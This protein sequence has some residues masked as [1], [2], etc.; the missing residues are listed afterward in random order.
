VRDHSKKPGRDGKSHHVVAKP[1]TARTTHDRS[2]DHQ[3]LAV[4][5]LDTPPVA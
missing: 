1:A 5:W 4:A 2:S 3:I